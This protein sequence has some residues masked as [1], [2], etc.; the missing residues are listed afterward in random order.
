M[1]KEKSFRFTYGIPVSQ[2]ADLS[3]PLRINSVRTHLLFLLNEQVTLTLSRGPCTP[4]LTNTPIRSADAE[5]GEK[6]PQ[7]PS[8]RAQLPAPGN[9]HVLAHRYQGNLDCATP[10][11]FT[12]PKLYWPDAVWLFFL[13]LT[14]EALPNVTQRMGAWL[15]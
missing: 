4:R 10:E 1:S 7:N 12:T 13:P 2:Q 9:L 8:M 15:R 14:V 3:P 5:Q 6:S 11:P